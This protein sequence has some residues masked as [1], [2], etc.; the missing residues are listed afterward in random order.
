VDVGEDV[1]VHQLV[2][3]VRNFLRLLPPDQFA[4]WLANPREPNKQRKKRKAESFDPQGSNAIVG[5]QCRN[6]ARIG[7]EVVEASAGNGGGLGGSFLARRAALAVDDFL[8]V[9]PAREVGSLS[10]LHL[11]ILGHVGLQDGDIGAPAQL[12]G[13]PLVGRRLVADDANDGV[14]RVTGK[15]GQELPLFGHS[16]S[17]FGPRAAVDSI[18]S[19]TEAF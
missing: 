3:V 11:V 8:D 14:V 5:I 6:V 1:G 12:F 7:E 17:G 2:E 18:S 15:L 13:H 16:Q 9:R 19:Y 10:H 4:P